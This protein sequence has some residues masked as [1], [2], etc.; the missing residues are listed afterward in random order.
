MSS[1]K[2]AVN[3]LTGK[4]KD[5]A[6]RIAV[7]EIIKYFEKESTVDKFCYFLIDNDPSKE[8]YKYLEQ[9]KEGDEIAG[10]VTELLV[11]KWSDLI[12]YLATTEGEQKL[13]KLLKNL[14]KWSDEGAGEQEEKEQQQQ[15]P[16]ESPEGEAMPKKVEAK[17]RKEVKR[18]KER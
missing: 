1:V 18:G 14:K 17:M 12:D 9:R 15:Q 16:I 2:H 13:L 11:F 8:L 4:V 7:E 10:L 6:K 5:I 3:G